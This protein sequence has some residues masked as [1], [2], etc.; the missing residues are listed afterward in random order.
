MTIRRRTPPLPLPDTTRMDLTTA[1]LR[2]LATLARRRRC[3]RPGGLRNLARASAG[4]VHAATLA[5]RSRAMT[6]IAGECIAHTRPNTAARNPSPPAGRT[7]HSRPTAR[8]RTRGWL[9]L[10][11]QTLADGSTEHAHIGAAANRKA[12][13]DA[14]RCEAIGCTLPANAGACPAATPTSTPRPPRSKRGAPSNASP[15]SPSSAPAGRPS[16][17]APPAGTAPASTSRTALDAPVPASRAPLSP[18]APS[19][20]PDNPLRQAHG[21][22]VYPPCPD[23]DGDIEWT[24]GDPR[25]GRCWQCG[26]LLL[27]R[28]RTPMIPR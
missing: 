25:V 21:H 19:L 16:S 27:D 20:R 9:I 24:E 28:S 7:P 12:Y 11:P 17:G 22:P 4:L 15:A 3:G 8:T 6:T 2:H 14:R 5:H 23:C 1:E 13:L 26:A 10:Q 18:A